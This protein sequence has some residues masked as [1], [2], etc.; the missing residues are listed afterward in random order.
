MALVRHCKNENTTLV[1]RNLVVL[2]MVAQVEANLRCDSLFLYDFLPALS[3]CSLPSSPL[4][5][6]S[7]VR[8]G[9]NH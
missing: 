9:L 6:K 2:L 1:Y 3:C 8:I 7:S 5:F 4:G